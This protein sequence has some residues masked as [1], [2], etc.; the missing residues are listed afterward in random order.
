MKSGRSRLLVW[1]ALAAC[2]LLSG[3]AG[4][5][6]DLILVNGAV[7][8]LNPKQPWAQ[9]VV[10]ESGRIAYVGDD[11]HARAHRSAASQIIDLHG[12][13]VVPGFHDAHT[14]PMSSGLRLLRCSLADAKSLESLYAH[15][16]SCAAHKAPEEWLIGYG[17]PDSFATKLTRARLDAL[18]PDRPVFLTNPDG[19]KAWANTKALVAAGLDPKTTPDVLKGDANNRLRAKLPTPTEGEYR[20][21]LKRTSAMANSFGITSIFDAAVKPPM[22]D[23]Y[24]AADRAGELTV[25]VVAAQAVNPKAGAAQVDGMVARSRD[26]RST[27]LRADAAKIFLDEEIEM[28]T[29][30]LLAPYADQLSISGAL[31]IARPELNALVRRLDA[32]GFMIHMHAMGD[33]AVRAGLDAIE[34]AERANGPR[35]RRHQLAHLGVVDP[36]DIPRF[37]RLGVTANFQPLWFPADDPVASSTEAALGQQRSRR[38][39]PMGSITRSGGRTVAGSDWPATSMSPLEGMQAAITR[40]PLDA[41]LPARQPQERITL[42]AMIAAYTSNAAWAAREDD[43]DG[44]VE[45]GKAADLVV[46]ERNLLETDAHALHKVRVLLT[47]LDGKPVYR[48]PNFALR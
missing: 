41:H 17:W 28:H 14:H 33:G 37:A 47:L 1:I 25:R 8:T 7:Y 15:V 29:A 46:L 4:R 21:A 48:N 20:A 39:M 19:Y 12:K 45:P 35:D 32:E 38:I 44:T 13:M 3:A 31:F 2:F 11:A 34:A 26:V 43:I 16:R 22:L 10:I 6:S 5:A 24:S 42:A 23:A 30:A 18:V 40:Q 27:R 9:A 36:D